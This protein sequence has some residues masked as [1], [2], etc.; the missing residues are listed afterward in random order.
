MTTKVKQ[1]IELLDLKPLSIGG[2]FFRRT[3][4]SNELIAKE[5]LPE[6]Y[7]SSRPFS[8]AIYYLLTPETFSILHKL[9]TD[10]LFH[11][12]LG[13]PVEM[14]QL[15]DDGT[16]KI[17]KLGND[18]LSGYL[19]Q[20]VVLKN[21]WQGTKLIDGGEFALFG[22]TLTPG[23]EDEDFIPPNKSELLKNYA[24][25]AELINKLT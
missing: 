7:P 1:I 15:F 14:L 25:F 19:P 16:G 5:N 4:S 11:F 9:P 12:Y 3:Y 6:R 22:A 20:V 21:T 13:D 8:S 17:I 2:G 10:E 23:F 24:E 18:V